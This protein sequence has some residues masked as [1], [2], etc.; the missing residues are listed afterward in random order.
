MSSGWT[1]LGIG[2]LVAAAIVTPRVACS[3]QELRDSLTT[4]V[5][6]RGTA[7]VIIPGVLGSAYGFRKVVP[8]LLADDFRVAVIDPLGFGGSP[9]PDGANYSYTSQAARLSDAIRELGMGSVILVCHALSGT[10]CLRLAYHHPEQVRGIVSINGG[11]SEQAGTVEMRVA[12]KVARVVLFVMGEKFAIA[13]LRKGLIESSGDPSWVTESVVANYVAPFGSDARTVVRS[14][15]QIA[16]AHETEALA[17]NLSRVQAPELLLFGPV[18]RNP[19]NP[20]LSSEER[21]LLRSG[22]RKF[23]QE[24][25]PGAGEYIHEEQPERVIAAIKKMRDQTR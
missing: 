3:Q 21:A 22:I 8:A 10:I 11:A 24:D 9:R 1:A 23:Q 7:V 17:P 13:R 15:Q 20:A 6:G 14:L 25:V 5:A 2:F 16:G 4:T 12:L 19:K 18:A